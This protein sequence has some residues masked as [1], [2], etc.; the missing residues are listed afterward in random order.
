MVILK[1][2]ARRS[3]RSKRLRCVYRLSSTG[4]WV[5]I[6]RNRRLVWLTAWNDEHNNYCKTP[7]QSWL[8]LWLAAVFG[9]DN[10]VTR[11]KR[12]EQNKKPSHVVEEG[13]LETQSN[14]TN[15]LVIDRFLYRNDLHSIVVKKHAD[16]RKNT[17]FI[18]G[19]DYIEHTNI[20]VQ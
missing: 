7:A 2:Y 1:Y 6:N 4:E 11:A 20:N 5:F 8:S 18:Y 14:N 13:H 3:E 15:L 16:L 17:N 10:F 9:D 19:D 12:T